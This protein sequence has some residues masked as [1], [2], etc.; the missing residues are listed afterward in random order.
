MTHQ[1]RRSRREAAR[2]ERGRSGRPRWLLPV[3]GGA[4]VVGVA[5]IAI[6]LT[7]GSGGGSTPAPS[8]S[9]R[10]AAS[11]DLPVISGASLPVFTGQGS[12]PALGMTIPTVQGADFAG[13]PVDIALDGKPKVLL[14]LSHSCSHCQ[15][16]VPVVQDWIDGGGEPD[17]IELI[18]V[19]TNIDPA[20][21]NY[22]PDAWL[23]REGWTV[24]VIVDPTDSVSAAYGLSAFPFWVF[25]GSDGEVA[26][27][28]TGEL[29]INDLES[30]LDGL[31]IRS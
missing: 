23:E 10:P 7:S 18:S 21:P 31:R 14:F 4:L 25:V 13:Q 19:A 2:A 1:A 28:L 5:A 26:L 27:R 6:V 22:P 15:A 3:I 11:G 9:S 29:S 8:G 16:E 17:D 20:L 24:P 12:D 30:I